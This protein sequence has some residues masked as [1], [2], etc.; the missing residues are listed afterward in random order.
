ME[1]QSAQHESNRQD[2]V[3]YQTNDRFEQQEAQKNGRPKWAN[4][5]KQ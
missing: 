5:S 2:E 1:W 4:K 3:P